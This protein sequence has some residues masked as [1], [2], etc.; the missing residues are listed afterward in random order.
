MAIVR[1]D[2][3][4]IRTNK[5]I[6]ERLNNITNEAD[7]FGIETAYRYPGM[8]VFRKDNK[9][10]YYLDA[11]TPLELQD[12]ANWK[13][14]QIG[15]TVNDGV[16]ISGFY[17]EQDLFL[18]RSENLSDV[19]INLENIFRLDVSNFG[20]NLTIADTTIQKAFNTINNL[21]LISLDDLSPYVKKD[22]TVPF[23]APQQGVPAVKPLDLVVKNQ[24]PL[25]LSE[26]INDLGFI[27]DYTVILQDVKQY[28]NQLTI[29]ESQIS[30]LNHFSGD[31]NDL[32]N[33]PDLSIFAN[34][35]S[36]PTLSGFPVTGQ[37]SILYLAEDT[38]VLYRWDG[39]QYV[40]TSGTLALGETSYTAYRGDRGKI[41]YDHSQLTSGNPHNV[42]KSD[43]GLSNVNNTSDLDKPISTATQNAL[44]LKLNIGDNIS[45]LVNNVGYITHVDKLE[46]ITDVDAYPTD[47]SDAYLIHKNGTNVWN[48][49]PIPVGVIENYDDEL[50]MG[51]SGG[52][53]R[54]LVGED[55]FWLVAL[56]AFSSTNNAARSFDNGKTWEAITI[57]A[58]DWDGCKMKNGRIILAAQTNGSNLII[59][60]DFGDTWQ[61]QSY[62]NLYATSIDANDSDTWI[63]TRWNVNAIFRSTNNGANWSS[64]S[65]GSQP[66]TITY[67]YDDTWILT[68]GTGTG[69]RVERSTDNGLTWNELTSI[70]Q[71]NVN[72]TIGY[73]KRVWMAFDTNTKLLYKS[74]DNGDT[75]TQVASQI[76][77]SGTISRIV[78]GA[79]MWYMLFGNKWYI[80]TDEGVTFTVL[81]GTVPN[82]QYGKALYST[83]VLMV[84]TTSG[85]SRVPILDSPEYFKTLNNG[86]TTNGLP[87]TLA[88][89]QNTGNHDIIITS[90]DKIDFSNV[91][92]GELLMSYPNGGY[93]QHV[94]AGVI[95][96]KVAT[97]R[98]ENLSNEEIL[99]ITNTGILRVGSP[100]I[101]GQIQIYKEN[102][103]STIKSE[104]LT[105]SHT[106]IL[107]DSNINFTGGN[108]G[109]V[110]TLTAQG[111][112]PQPG[113]SS[114]GG[115]VDSVQEGDGIVVNSIDPNNPVVGL[116]NNTIASLDLANSSLQP[117]D[118]ISLLNNDAQYLTEVYVSDIVATGIPNYNTFLRGD[119]VW[120]E[121]SGGTAIDVNPDIEYTITGIT[122]TLNGATWET[123]LD[124][125]FITANN[126]I[127]FNQWLSNTSASIFV[128]GVLIPNS[129]WVLQPD[130]NGGHE[131]ILSTNFQIVSSSRITIQI[132]NKD[133]NQTNSGHED[134]KYTSTGY[135]SIGNGTSWVLTLPNI[136]VTAN[137]LIIY[138]QWLSPVSANIYINGVLIPKIDWT[139]QADGNSGHE[140]LV[141]TDF[142]V[143]TTMEITIQIQ[144]T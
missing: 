67:G 72:Y 11:T 124:N 39:S 122:S 85:V 114:S 130:G 20:N 103:Q 83:G 93:V 141:S 57:P 15:N 73:Y 104:P 52:G 12:N 58:R 87:E 136:F 143:D 17:E 116:N 106:I 126:T 37:S 55:G 48:N 24:L 18:Q 84:A 60:D 9:N 108:V 31:Y 64:I 16:V 118:N 5:H 100:Q 140:I 65:V 51:L 19:I 40:I 46:D 91:F 36:Y 139:I 94:A 7:L 53:L 102:F 95:K 97:K 138:N 107:P 132:Q 137:N 21:H 134:A 110:L 75:W 14:Y 70:P 127:I 89:N 112:E 38:G 50:E 113:G 90:G 59:S 35:E 128:N 42:T 6:D 115:Q 66:R 32:F 1:N 49:L 105:S 47:G 30:D 76:T 135:F 26:L 109:N 101:E 68:R 120:A 121:V 4:D 117:N 10:F 144:R 29:T 92:I 99:A 131:I 74:I 81:S 123:T 54:T 80:S 34:F 133:L 33:K 86:L 96:E 43:I 13:I 3:L 98:W 23:I 8:L 82:V 125:T 2:N 22:G 79:G 77:F 63:I 78:G 69:Y 41:A 45:E 129:Y 27:S 25:K 28:E 88:I 111:W 119:G 61:A 44:D 142:E 62:V 71:Q 56:P